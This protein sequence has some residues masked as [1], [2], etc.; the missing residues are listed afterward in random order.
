MIARQFEP[1]DHLARRGASLSA[2]VLEG[3]RGGNSRAF[4]TCCSRRC[5]RGK[6]GR[7]SRSE[8]QRGLVLR[9]TRTPLHLFEVESRRPTTLYLA[10]QNSFRTTGSQA[11]RT[12]S[13]ALTGVVTVL[14][15]EPFD[16]H[17]IDEGQALKLR[18]V[19]AQLVLG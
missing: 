7:L 19:G 14:R 6:P 8:P 4:E 15:H 12:R 9:T 16:S 17:L 11:V 5:L 1:G 13:D 3:R 18:K 10:Q 2:G